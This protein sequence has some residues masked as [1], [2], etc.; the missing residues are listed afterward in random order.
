MRKR[1][2]KIKNQARNEE[3]LSKIPKL[4]TRQMKIINSRNLALQQ[5]LKLTLAPLNPV[6]L[7]QM[8]EVPPLQVQCPLMQRVGGT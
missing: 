3:V 8:L 1:G 4:T 5:M 2:K 6:A 7:M